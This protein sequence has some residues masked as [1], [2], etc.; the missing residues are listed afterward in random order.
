MREEIE[1][2]NERALFERRDDRDTYVRLYA[3]NFPSHACLP[4]EHNINPCIMIAIY[5]MSNGEI[6]GFS[7]FFQT[8]EE[9][10]IKGIWFSG[11]VIR[12][13]HRGSGIGSC[14]VHRVVCFAKEFM[15]A[16]YALVRIQVDNTASLRMFG[17][18]G[19]F[20]LC[21]NTDNN[22]VIQSKLITG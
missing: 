4:S 11:T 5:R 15:N 19:F 9:G 2:V 6:A 17:K 7:R 13:R 21:K 14:L 8:T 20:D 1:F 12:S 16:N 10:P 22:H 18:C 3:E